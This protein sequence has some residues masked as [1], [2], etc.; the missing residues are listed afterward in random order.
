MI[1]AIL[2]HIVHGV[3]TIGMVIVILAFLGQ[4]IHDGKALYRAA[5]GEGCAKERHKQK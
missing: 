3:V 2:Q 4:I 5:F 1:Q